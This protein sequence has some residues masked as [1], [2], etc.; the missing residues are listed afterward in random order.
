M[1]KLPL[2]RLGNFVAN[3]RT[4]L[5]AAKNEDSRFEGPLARV[6]D[7][8]ERLRS[9]TDPFDIDSA[10][11]TV[12]PLLGPLTS[13]P[14]GNAQNAGEFLVL[15]VSDL[16]RDRETGDSRAK[17]V[18][19]LANKR[20]AAW[21]TLASAQFAPGAVPAIAEDVASL[22]RLAKRIDGLENLDG[23]RL[24]EEL[25][26]LQAR[27]EG[28]ADDSGANGRDILALVSSYLELESKRS[29]PGAPTPHDTA[30]FE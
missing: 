16:L 24:L 14:A 27:L 22:R 1:A 8:R 28:Q 9:P 25:G 10:V 26:S 17:K 4:A 2:P 7:L 21:L 18:P 11:D 15:V 19:K 13:E 23:L 20:L 5:T 3:A 30:E 6:K 29:A 12:L